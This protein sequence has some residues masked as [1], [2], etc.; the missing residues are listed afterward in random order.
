[1]SEAA[2]VFP[3]L[4]AEVEMPRDG[5]LSRTVLATDGARVV[6]FG[7]DT[8]QELSEHSSPMEAILHFIS[9]EVELTLG[10]ETVHVAAGAWVHMPPKLKHRLVAKAPTV[11][12][13]ILIKN[14][15]E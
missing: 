11:M 6:V 2:T 14:A 9:G 10:D 13:L 5:I 4:A 15:A 7:F 8:G 3:D 12:E 1:M